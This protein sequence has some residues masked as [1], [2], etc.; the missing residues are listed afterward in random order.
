MQTT[1]TA[2][3]LSDTI[4]SNVIFTGVPAICMDSSG[5]SWKRSPGAATGLSG[6]GG[7]A[8]THPRA[9]KTR[10][11]SAAILDFKSPLPDPYDPSPHDDANDI[12]PRE[13]HLGVDRRGAV[14]G[15]SLLD[16]KDRH[17]LDRHGTVGHEVRRE[18]ARRR[19]GARD[20]DRADGIER[21][22]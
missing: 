9:E 2:Q 11:P 16:G 8:C 14:H 10:I 4:F 21:A 19:A 13:V 12:G 15:M 6:G 7:G 18:R 20:L 17:R 1:S 22:R 5:R 3:R